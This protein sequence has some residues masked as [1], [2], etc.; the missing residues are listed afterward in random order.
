MQFILLFMLLSPVTIISAEDFDCLI[1]PNMVV[2]V[3]SAVEGV[4]EVFH[5]ERS[6]SVE[7]DQLL[8]ELEAGVEIAAV[9]NARARSQMKGA[10]N[11]Q[12][13]SLE[14]TERRFDRIK[15]LFQKGLV[16]SHEMDEAET[17]VKLAR[18]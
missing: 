10:L 3:S 17:Q 11:S 2:D 6:D 14:F 16:S 15:H 18:A 1:E 4:V 8:V 5:V 9:N 12:R 13:S 7:Q